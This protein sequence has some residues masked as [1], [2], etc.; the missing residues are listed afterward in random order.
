MYEKNFGVSDANIQWQRQVHSIKKCSTYTGGE[1]TNN[2]SSHKEEL[3]THKV[4]YFW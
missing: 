1:D 2:E 4:D 3:S